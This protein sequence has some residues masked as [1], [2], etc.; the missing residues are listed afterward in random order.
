MTMFPPCEAVQLIWLL[1]PKVEAE[2][3]SICEVKSQVKVAGAA[4]VATG[5]FKLLVTV[6]LAVLVHCEAVLVMVKR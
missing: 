1:V 3:L 6:T 4:T 2:A 5:V